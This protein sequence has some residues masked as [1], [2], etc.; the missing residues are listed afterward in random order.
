MPINNKSASKL[1]TDGKAIVSTGP[2][3]ERFTNSVLLGTT[4]QKELEFSSYTSLITI[5][6][7]CCTDSHTYKQTYT[8]S[9]AKT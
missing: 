9:K 2:S 5:F 4:R 7:Y 6:L 3:S 1:L 8:Y